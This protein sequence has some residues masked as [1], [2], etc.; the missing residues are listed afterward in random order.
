MKYD[1]ALLLLPLTLAALAFYCPPGLSDDYDSNLFANSFFDQAEPHRKR[2]NAKS[3]FFQGQISHWDAFG[4]WSSDELSALVKQEFF[5]LSQLMEKVKKNNVLGPEHWKL[6]GSKSAHLKEGTETDNGKDVSYFIIK[7]DQSTNDK[8]DVLF[9]NPVLKPIPIDGSV[10]LGFWARSPDNKK[11]SVS[12]ELSENPAADHNKNEFTAELS[13]KWRYYSCRFDAP[14]NSP[15]EHV[16]RFKLGLNPGTIEIEKNA[17]LLVDETRRREIL[18]AESISDRI[19]LY[20]CGKLT[21]T[22]QNAKNSPLKNSAITISQIKHEYPFGFLASD[23]DPANHSP[24]QRKI[25]ANIKQLFNTAVIPLNWSDIEP[26]QGKPDFTHVES[27]VHWCQAN[28]LNV[29]GCNLLSSKYYP[30]WAP[31]DPTKAAGVIRTHVVDTNTKLSGLI[32]QLE[33]V[34]DLNNAVKSSKPKSGEQAWIKSLVPLRGT[35]NGASLVALEKLLV[36]AHD[37]DHSKRTKFILGVDDPTYIGRFLEE[38][39]KF[40]IMPD[41]IEIE[42]KVNYGI[43]PRDLFA[44]LELIKQFHTPAYIYVRCPVENGDQLQDSLQKALNV[45]QMAYSNSS[46]CGIIWN[47]L[48]DR[49][50][51]QDPV[52]GLLKSDGST[53]PIYSALNDLIH[54]QWWTSFTGTTDDTGSASVTA[55]F[56]GDYL[57]SV[58]NSKGQ[59][60]SKQIK[61]SKNN[62][63]KQTI[64]VHI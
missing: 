10:Y 45:Y 51:K 6:T 64:I 1:S 18:S 29:I 54:K 21:I 15:G 61:F 25:Q 9:E 50:G 16:I 41:A 34:N 47:G 28:H 63:R 58:K 11:A 26:V 7:V 2:R 31:A 49:T 42:Q 33:V 4:H 60:V 19:H 36:W 3:Q 20:R 8:N 38:K 56:Y 46:V 59:I 39:Q 22:I 40:G 14:Q 62:E 23:L 5:L 35:T 30:D 37:A 57:I 32:P 24:Q 48:V 12:Y 17:H 13:R 44:L 43:N 53:K 27:L 52:S 55:A